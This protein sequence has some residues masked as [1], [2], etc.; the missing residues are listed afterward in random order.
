M[1]EKAM[2]LAASLWGKRR[3]L[4][5]K[6][7]E[8]IEIYTVYETVERFQL[9]FVSLN[10]LSGGIKQISILDLASGYWEVVCH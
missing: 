4:I 2:F 10:M 7:T 3:K 9:Q 1:E 8:R 6:I 5:I